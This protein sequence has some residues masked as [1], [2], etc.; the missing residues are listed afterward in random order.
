MRELL[1]ATTVP[2]TPQTVLA[3]YRKLIARKH[4]GR[5]N[6]KDPGRPKISHEVSN[7]VIRFKEENPRWGYTRIHDC[8]VHLG[9][10][11]GETTVK[12]ILLENG[13]DPEPDLARKTT[14]K[15]FFKSHWNVLA[16]CD[17]FSIEETVW[18]DGNTPWDGCAIAPD[19][20]R[21]TPPALSFSPHLSCR[22]RSQ[23]LPM[24]QVAAPWSFAPYDSW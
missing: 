8:I 22:I 21:V 7:L 3:W 18:A 15:H 19:S 5:K 17:F 11:T 20:G 1:E 9:H 14:W 12:N 6:C 4:D 10:E 24:A 23:L 2:F 13:Y 16:A